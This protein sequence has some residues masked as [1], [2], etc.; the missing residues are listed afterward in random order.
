[1]SPQ[2]YKNNNIFIPF[3]IVLTS[4][5]VNIRNS[6]VIFSRQT[7][8]VYFGKPNTNICW[9]SKVLIYRSSGLNIT[10]M[11]FGVIGGRSLGIVLLCSQLL[12]NGV[13]KLEIV[14]R[15]GR[16]KYIFSYRLSFICRTHEIIPQRSLLFFMP[17]LYGSMGEVWVAYV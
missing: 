16:E 10:T 6:V 15:K 3:T 4:R 9:N 7:F 8:E 14:N 13:N 12:F 1:M 11:Y 2:T 17:F 5:R